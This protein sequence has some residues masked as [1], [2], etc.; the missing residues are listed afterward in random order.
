[1]ADAK[2]QIKEDYEAELARIEKL[3]KDD[4][5]KLATAKFELR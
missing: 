2:K 3:Y 1:M 4:P 5:K